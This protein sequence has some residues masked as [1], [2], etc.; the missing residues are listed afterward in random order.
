MLSNKFFQVIVLLAFVAF[1]VSFFNKNKTSDAP[2]L[3]VCPGCNVII[4]G[5]DA[6]QA[7][8]VS[9]L[10]YERE[11]TPAI[12]TLAKQGTSFRNAISAASWTVPSF[13]SMFTGLY[14]AEHK[15]VNKFSVF[16]K[17]KQTIANLTDLSP[18]VETLAEVFKANGYVTGGFTGDAGVN[19]QF[20]YNKGFDAYTDE[21]T[22]GSIENSS[23]HA[24]DWIAKNKDSK[25]FVF[26]H[27]YDDHGQFDLPANYQGRFAPE[28]YTGPYAGTKEE[29]RILREQGL[30]D[31]EISLTPDDVAFWRGWYD[32]KIRD[33]DYRLAQFLEKYHQLGIKNKTVIIV[34]SDHGTEFYEHKRFDHGFS[35]YDELVRVL[36]VFAVPGLPSQEIVSDQVTTLD[37]A[38]TLLDITGITASEKYR[39]QLR[40]K[41]LLSYLQNGKGE[42]RDV[43]METDYRNYTYK[44]GVRTTDGWKYI[45]TMETGAE[46][47]YSIKND[48]GET[49]NL[50]GQYPELTAKLKERVMNH[51]VKMGQDPI[52]PWETSC[53]PVYGDQCK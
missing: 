40:G 5:A 4:V 52:G 29:Q 11:T 6:L 10:G 2:A 41:S 28:N 22:F 46:E 53:V 44:R 33:A 34:V 43:F 1:A 16:T 35:L 26:L 13:M 24:L 8:H 31:G 19:S 45:M 23:A 48:P 17:E 9:H 50:T 51:L 12:D 36:F 32:S 49:T 25:L 15:V 3:P 30:A 7:S 47:L 38:P 37:M 39:S 18:Q 20:G 14:P 21:K 27:G 42:A